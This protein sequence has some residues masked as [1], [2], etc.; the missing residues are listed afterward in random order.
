MKNVNLKNLFLKSL[1]LTTLL[2]GT[3]IAAEG[4]STAVTI[5]NPAKTTGIQ[6]GDVLTRNIAIETAPGQKI[7]ATSLPVKG[8]RTDG[9][10]LTDVKL[11]SEENDGKATH[12]LALR[13]QV[14]A[15]AV[16]SVVM[17][18][19]AESVELSDTRKIDIPSWNFWFSPLVKTPLPNVLPNV[20]PQDRAPLIDTTHHVSALAIYLSLLLAGLIG[21]IYVNADRQWLPFMGGAFSRAHR[22]IKKVARSRED[23][24]IKVKKALLT[25]HQAFNQTYGKNLFRPDVDDFIRQHPSY[26]KIAAEIASF[27]ERSSQALFSK[28]EHDQAGLVTSLQIFSKSLRDCER[29][30]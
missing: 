23:D 7:T 9:I 2:A 15:D 24:N 5:K 21:A 1:F 19:P 28:R 29:G 22:S 10:E 8:T 18:L 14:F 6:I 16:S 17:K 13:Y 11:S 27:F 3:A 20:Q 12:T 4:N 25:L 26:Q 30:V